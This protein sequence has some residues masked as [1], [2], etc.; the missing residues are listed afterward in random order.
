MWIP[1]VSHLFPLILHWVHIGFSFVS[2]AMGYSALECTAMKCSAIGSTTME[3]R[4]MDCIGMQPNG[5]HWIAMA[6]KSLAGFHVF[7]IGFTFGFRKV[8]IRYPLIPMRFH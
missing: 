3:R 7:S 6:W 1:L 2:V 5:L 8:F 4:R